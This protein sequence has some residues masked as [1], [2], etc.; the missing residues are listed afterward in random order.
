[1]QRLNA[2]AAFTLLA[3]MLITFLLTRKKCEFENKDTKKNW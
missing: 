1:M 3:I 2:Q